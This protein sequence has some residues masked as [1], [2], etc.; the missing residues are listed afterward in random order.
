[1]PDA[2]SGD[3]GELIEQGRI[4]RLMAWSRHPVT[5]LREAFTSGPLWVL[6]TLFALNGVDEL[7]RTAFGVLAPDIA[8]YFGTDLAGMFTLLA[9]VSMVALAL[10]VPIATLAD[11]HN[12]VRLAVLGA[13]LMAI[14]TSLTG[15][16]PSIWVLAITMAAAGLGKAFIEPTH[17]SLLTDHFPPEIRSRV[18]AFHRAG[19]AV[20]AFVGPLLA[21]FLAFYFSWRV[22]FIVFGPIILIAAVVAVRIPEPIRGVWERRA[23]GA[24]EHLVEIEEPPASMSESWRMC[25]KVDSL[26]QIYRTLPFLAPAVVGFV[27]FAGFLYADEFGLDERSRGVIAALAEPSQLIG[28]IIGARVGTKLFLRDPTLVFKFLGRV[29][30]GASALTLLFAVSPAWFITV[31]GIQLPWIAVLLNTAISA[32]LAFLLPGILAAL[33]MAIPPRARSMGFAMMSIF[34]IPGLAILPV[35]GALGDAL[36]MRVGMALVAPM[37][38]IGG[39]AIARCGR[40]IMRDILDVAN[41]AA[42]RADA[43]FA[44]REGHSKLLV[45]RGLDVGY[46]SVPVL[47]GVDMY[48]EEGEILALLGTNGAGK[49][50]LLGAIAGVTEADRGAVM[51]DGVDITHAPPEQIAAKGIV[52]AP[53]GKGVFP[54]LTVAENLRIAAWLLKGDEAEIERRLAEVYEIFPMLVERASEPAANLSGGQQQMLTLAMVLLSKPRLLM[55]DELSLGLAPL[56]VAQVLDVVREIAA[57]GTTV[58]VVEQSVNVALSIAERA[59]FLEKGEVRFTGPTSDLLEQPEVLRSVF[60][61]ELDEPAEPTDTAGTTSPAA[62]HEGSAEGTGTGADG[63]VLELA[64]I[65]RRFGGIIAVSDVDLSVGRGEIVGI[66]GTNGAGKTTLFDIISGFT[67]ADSGRILLNGDDI[68][69]L[70]PRRR[71]LAGLGRSFQEA[72]LFPSLTVEQ[73][74]A[75]AH[76]ARSEASNALLQGL[77]M[78]ASFESEQKVAESVEVLIE[79]FGLGTFRSKFVGELS[80]GTRRIVDLAALVALEPQVVLLDEPSSGIAQREAEA[81]TD[82]IQG[83]RDEFDLTILVIEHDIALLRSI[84][85]RLVAME[86]GAVIADGETSAVLTNP[87]V[88]ESYLGG[89]AIVLERSGEIS[90]NSPHGTTND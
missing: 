26:R 41:T 77:W 35:V 4:S 37:F 8:D 16:S 58:V 47:F 36:G 22:P 5:S 60:F 42:A 70:S 18:F 71:A 75:N 6:V 24:P 81:L 27:T 53:G 19:N 25:W 7:T 57:R 55:I 38:V 89:S 28:L 61:G 80:T 72:A 9:F 50:T 85:P 1:M 78:P 15:F 63:P 88:L 2:G 14:F 65:T 30:L 3:T 52:I 11:R 21:G 87:A 90:T 86:A 40:Y 51:L 12:R 76:E 84:A 33:S 69:P 83:I 23:A 13:T 32:S 39:F 46:D 82:V 49:S 68:T 43:L 56:M 45:V 64:G 48:V 54:T 67:P 34:V 10:Q 29:S 31:A 44:R 62:L 73:V 59:Y 74:L 20:G 79:R 17:N 66:I